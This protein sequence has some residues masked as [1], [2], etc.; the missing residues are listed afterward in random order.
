MTEQNVTI[1]LDEELASRFFDQIENASYDLGRAADVFSM[2]AENMAN[3]SLKASPEALAV[4]ELSACA[5]LKKADDNADA[6]QKLKS[7]IRQRAHAVREQGAA[8]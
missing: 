2:L 5:L 3:G 4:C 8:S 1:P 6:M 7:E